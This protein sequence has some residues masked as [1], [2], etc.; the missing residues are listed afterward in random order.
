MVNPY[1]D[2]IWSKYSISPHPE[3]GMLSLHETCSALIKYTLIPSDIVLSGGGYVLRHDL[4]TTLPHVISAMDSLLDLSARHLGLVNIL[5]IG[6]AELDILSGTGVR[7]IL[8][9]QSQVVASWVS[10]LDR[11]CAAKHQLKALCSG[12]TT[13][14]SL[15]DWASRVGSIASSLPLELRT[16]L[17]SDLVGRFGIEAEERS[18]P[19]APESKIHSPPAS[20]A[21]SSSST[22]SPRIPS[23]LLSAPSLFTLVPDGKIY[24]ADTSLDPIWIFDLGRGRCSLNAEFLYFVTDT[25]QQMQAVLTQIHSPWYSKSP[26]FQI[27]PNT[28][29]EQTLRESQDIDLLNRAW[30]MLVDRMC[31]ASGTFKTY[32]Q[33]ENKT[34]TPAPLRTSKVLPKSKADEDLKK[35]GETLAEFTM[36]QKDSLLT[37]ELLSPTLAEVYCEGKGFARRQEETAADAGPRT[38]RESQGEDERLSERETS[39]AKPASTME[40]S[41]LTKERVASACSDCS[42]IIADESPFANARDISVPDENSGRATMNEDRDGC[43][44]S[45]RTTE[46]AAAA[47]IGSVAY[48]SPSSSPPASAHAVATI[49]NDGGLEGTKSASSP[50]TQRGKVEQR[51]AALLDSYQP[52]AR[53]TRY[54]L[55]AHS[56]NL[57]LTPASLPSTPVA[58]ALIKPVFDSGNGENKLEIVLEEI[59]ENGDAYG[60]KPHRGV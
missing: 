39:S 1:L 50:R 47:R 42:R 7:H 49:V 23:N 5:A 20:T 30:A 34:A 44:K 29:L 54:Q 4:A 15:H 41:L 17:P 40:G 25:V 21:M 45:G 37:D 27:D 58:F 13:H 16:K 53:L 33:H 8:A 35:E 2:W 10:I 11:I 57:P 56:T 3:Q 48:G 26:C 28:Q 9:T 38:H 36:N 24:A 22:I 46:S 52:D 12:D 14:S 51:S 59:R 6:H 19:V 55:L 31:Q 32:Q 60:A 43:A 18:P